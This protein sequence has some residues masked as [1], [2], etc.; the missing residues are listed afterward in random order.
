MARHH[1]PVSADERF[2][3]TNLIRLRRVEAASPVFANKMKKDISG[4]NDDDYV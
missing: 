1:R 3:H 4:D 2:V